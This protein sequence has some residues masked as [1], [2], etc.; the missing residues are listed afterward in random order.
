MVLLGGKGAEATKSLL[1][2]RSSSAK[3]NSGTFKS[4][5]HVEIGTIDVY[6][7]TFESGVFLNQDLAVATFYGCFTRPLLKTLF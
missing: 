1:V 7:G 5:V 3:I 4:E 2:D 6:G